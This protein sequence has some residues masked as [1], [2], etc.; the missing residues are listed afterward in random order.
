MKN[1]HDFSWQSALKTEV[2]KN[3]NKKKIDILQWKKKLRE[4]R[5]IFDI[6]KWL[7]KSEIGIFWSLD[8][9]RKLIWQIFFLWKNAIFHTI[10]LPFDAEIDE[11]FLNVI[12][13]IL[14]KYVVFYSITNLLCSTSIHKH[15]QIQTHTKYLFRG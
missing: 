3:D 11:K 1:K 6:E 9:E 12:Y 4:I 13:Y 8:F 14:T 2:F 7:W 15:S 10:K 5:I